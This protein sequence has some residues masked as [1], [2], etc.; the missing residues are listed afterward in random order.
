LERLRRKTLALKKEYSDRRGEAGFN[1]DM[2]ISRWGLILCLGL[3]APV[4]FGQSTAGR[5]LQGGKQESLQPEAEQLFALANQ[6]RAEQGAGPLKWDAALATAARQ[7]CVRM[8]AEGQISHR[9]GGEPSVTER[10]G[11]AG[12]HF[13][14]LEENVAIGPDPGTIHNDWMHSQGHRTNLLNPEV[15]R[16]GVAV[17]ASRGV[18]YAV[19]D[20]ARGVQ[21]QTPAEVEA[22]IG[23][24]IQVSGVT[25][26]KDASFARAACAMDRGLP[27]T[28]SNQEPQFVIRWQDADVTHLP[29]GL[30]NRLSSGQFHQAAV[31]SCPPHD[32]EG[33]FTMHRV[34]VLLY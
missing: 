33:A 7:H 24:L 19:A 4:F 20:Y 14:L 12:A 28:K 29:Q 16:V 17:M 34:S 5:S 22:A 27:A 26:V 11:Q 13:S 25:I 1:E 32:V 21:D 2:G 30:V 3:A 8:V 6:A 9:Y 15:D 23:A 31:G 18:L 10:A